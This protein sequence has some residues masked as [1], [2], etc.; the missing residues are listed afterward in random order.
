MNDEANNTLLAIHSRLDTIE[1]KVSLIARADRDRVLPEL[2]A[3]VKRSPLVGQIYLLL[4][5]KRTQKDVQAELAKYGVNRNQSNV[6]RKMTD[7]TKEYGIIELAKGGSVKIY[8]KGSAAED[9]FNL[10]KRMEEWL[11]KF[12]KTVPKKTT[13]KQGGKKT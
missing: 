4:D 11:A 7:M 12:G 10:T 6:S 1:G 5:G 9:T 8:R 3:I 13:R 2:E